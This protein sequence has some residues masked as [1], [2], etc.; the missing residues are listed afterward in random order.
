MAMPND[1]TLGWAMLWRHP[2]NPKTVLLLH[3]VCV[4]QRNQKLFCWTSP[5]HRK[6]EGNN[7]LLGQRKL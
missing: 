6:I 4:E 5:S 2:H 1:D 3:G 7:L